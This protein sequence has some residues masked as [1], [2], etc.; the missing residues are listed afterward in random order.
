MTRRVTLRV[1]GSVI[2]DVLLF[3]SRNFITLLNHMS[4]AS[5]IFINKLFYDLRFQL[6]VVMFDSNVFKVSF[7]AVRDSSS[8][9]VLLN[10]LWVLTLYQFVLLNKANKLKYIF[11]FDFPLFRKHC[12]LSSFQV[13]CLF[14][15]Y[16][17]VYIN[18]FNFFVFF[19]GLVSI[20]CLIIFIIFS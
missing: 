14:I 16:V 20:T 7:D 11:Y 12:Y 1:A 2:D 3:S 10:V 13:L 5:V 15:T 4:E 9:H 19:Y 18:L 17:V 6:L 8:N